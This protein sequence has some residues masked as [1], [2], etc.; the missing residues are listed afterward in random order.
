[1]SKGFQF[2]IRSVFPSDL[3]AVLEVLKSYPGLNSKKIPLKATEM[4]LEIRNKVKLECL[5]TA[6]DLGLINKENTLSPEGFQLLQICQVQP[7]LFPEIVHFLY[8][9]LWTELEKS[10][11]CFS[12]T[13]QQVCEILWSTP[14][15]NIDPKTLA[16]EIYWRARAFSGKDTLSISAKSV[17]GALHWLEALNPP[18][19]KKH[20]KEKTFS[21][22]TFCPPELL[23]L[24][25]D[26][27][28]RVNNIPYGVGMILSSSNREVLCK[29]TLIEPTYLDRVLQYAFQ[30]FKFLTMSIEGGW[31]ERLILSRRPK[32]DDLV[33][34]Q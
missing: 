25:I 29:I 12:W 19:I 30:Q 7:N 13:Y 33:P 22:R 31:G 3:I 10:K 4:G 11:N 28:Y 1:M 9:N 17:N 27:I 15:S 23:I 8:F 32:L 14:S 6:K 21:R 24:A 20:K 16:S 34:L 5:E 18:V 2:H 26:R